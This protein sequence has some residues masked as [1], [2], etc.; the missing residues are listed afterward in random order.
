MVFT[1]FI[2]DIYSISCYNLHFRPGM[3]LGLEFEKSPSGQF[4]V[5]SKIVSTADDA[6][7]LS[8]TADEIDSEQIEVI[9]PLFDLDHT[10]MPRI[11][12]VIVAVDEVPVE[13]IGAEEVWQ[14]LLEM[15]EAAMSPGPIATEIGGDV[16]FCLTFQETHASTWG[17]IDYVEI[18]TAGMALSFIDDLNATLLD[19]I[20]SAFCPSAKG[21][22]GRQMFSHHCFQNLILKRN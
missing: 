13:E 8:S 7:V 19:V 1:L 20:N 3:Q 12:A 21:S 5:V 22:K 17:N 10:R 16:T 2:I 4:P 11:G 14:V 18:S 6:I 9:D 15:Q